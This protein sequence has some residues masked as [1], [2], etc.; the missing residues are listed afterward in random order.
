MGWSLKRLF[1]PS[2]QDAAARRLYNATV[3]QARTVAFYEL[4]SVPDTVT[5]R[6]DMISLH[7][8]LIMRRLMAEPS[9]KAFSEAYCGM[10]FTDMDRNLREM[11]VGDLSVGKKVKKLAEGFYGRA[12][13]YESAMNDGPEPMTVVLR[14]N[15]YGGED[16]GD[17]ALSAMSAYVRA[18]ADSLARQALADIMEGVVR[19]ESP[20]G[21]DGADA[22]LDQSKLDQ[23]KLD[24]QG[25]A[26][27]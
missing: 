9:A 11:G 21:P 10:I 12:T 5:G 1:R 23:P 2:A 26:G 24:Q 7:G 18:S 27:G 17:S 4:W 8:Y 16:P 25:G 3:A 19:F 13:A 15:I 6:F 20:P 14:R 22:E